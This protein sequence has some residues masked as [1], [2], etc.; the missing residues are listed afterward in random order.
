M[1]TGLPEHG[2]GRAIA[3][4][5]IALVV[6]LLSGAC[7]TYHKQS[8]EIKRSFTEADYEQALERV[9][10]IN[11]GSSELLYLYER[12]LLLHY[13][14]DYAESNEAFE[15]AELLLEELYTKS[16]TRQLATLAVS[17]NIGK[18]RGTSYEAILVN[19]YKILNYSLLGDLEGALVECRRVNRKLEYLRDSEGV[20]FANDPFIQYLTAMVYRAG[21]E[22]NDADVS[23]RVAASEYQELAVDYGVEAPWLLH[24][25]LM[26]TARLLGDDS[27][28]DFVFAD[29]TLTDCPRSPEPGEGVL[30][31][32][33]ECGYVAHKQE[34]KVVLPIFKQDDTSDVDALAEVLAA[35]EGV[36]VASYEGNRKIDYI[37]KVAVPVM[38]PTPVQWDYAV[39][40]PQWRAPLEA[41]S[42]LAEEVPPTVDDVDFRTDIVEN[43]DSYALAAFDEAYGKMLFRTIVRALTKYTAKEGAS[44]EDEALGW[45]VNWFNVATETADTREWTTLPEKILMARLILPAGRYDLHIGLFDGDGRHVDDVI[46]EDVFIGP[47]RTAFLN[48]RVF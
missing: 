29:S 41:D 12:G 16:V 28:G 13:R 37:L 14:D 19:Y 15:R 8:I 23:Y 43:V 30:N 7:S 21:R 17:D 48:H 45:V 26:E 25:D 10:E 34:R 20:F 44:N 11:R 46:I 36:A 2:R 47:G 18:Y 32:F 6:V 3:L 4:P 27:A 38:V 24:C 1:K 40:R 42:A 9:D 31:L 33:L 35:R 39:I 5:A 22:L